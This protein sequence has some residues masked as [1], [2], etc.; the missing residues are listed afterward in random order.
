MQSIFFKQNLL[1]SPER[2]LVQRFTD[3]WWGAA[4]AWGLLV[5]EWG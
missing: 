2:M 5:R 4:G 3:D 1:S